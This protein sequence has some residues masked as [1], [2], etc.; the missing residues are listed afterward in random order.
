MILRQVRSGDGTGTLS[1]ILGDDKTRSAVVIDPNIEDTMRI[2]D[3]AREAGLRIAA[4]IDTHTHAD[5]ISA[6]GELQRQ[7]GAKLIMHENTRNKWK[8]V[9]QGDRF[10][11]GDILRANAAFEVDRYVG[12]DEEIVVGSLSIRSFFTPGHSDNHVSLLVEGKLFTGDLLL[13]GQAGR[14]DLPTGSPAEQYESLFRKI[15]PLPDRT[16]IWPGHDYEG[17]SFSTLGEEKIRNPFLQQ[18]TKEEYLAFVGEFFPPLS[19][20][21]AGGKVILQCGTMRVPTSNE[22]FRS[23]RPHELAQMRKQTPGLF[24]LDVRQPFELAAFGAIEGVVNIPTRE[25]PRRLV[26]LPA[27]K[28]Q[29]VVVVCQTGSRSYEI[30]HYL[31]KQGYRNV[32]NL[33]GGT[34]SWVKSG[35]EVKK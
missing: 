5:H 7:L 15:L 6:A 21:V 28:S 1:Y 24:L 2:V 34:S 22:P 16:K 32:L 13:I 10:G 12:N 14:S 17:N 30:S 23:I 9:D 35:F 33:D 3:E 8:V 26:E 19:D 18:R 29:P 4:V 20:V 31:V 11:I 25:V 27:D